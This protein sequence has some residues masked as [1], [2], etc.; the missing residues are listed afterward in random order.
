MRAE[1]VFVKGSRLADRQH[2]RKNPT[3]LGLSNYCNDGGVSHTETSKKH[4]LAIFSRLNA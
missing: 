1:N 3:G 2:Y 4:D